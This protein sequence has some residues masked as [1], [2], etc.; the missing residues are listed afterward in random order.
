MSQRHALVGYRNP[1]EIETKKTQ[2]GLSKKTQQPLVRCGRKLELP[3]TPCQAH[4]GS[5]ARNF[6]SHG[7][8]PRS[9]ISWGVFLMHGAHREAANIPLHG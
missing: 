7:M 6:G 2:Q 1:K 9:L 5:S 3:L 4:F 8:E